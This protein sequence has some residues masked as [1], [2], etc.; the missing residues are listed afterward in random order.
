MT[1]FKFRDA[2]LIDLEI[3]VE[4]YNST[5]ASRMVTADTDPVSVN[6]SINWFDK[7]NKII[8]MK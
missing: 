4:I 5:V 3:I 6:S 8:I 1:E 2:I 7:H